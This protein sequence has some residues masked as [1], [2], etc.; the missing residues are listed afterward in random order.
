MAGCSR[1]EEPETREFFDLTELVL[2]AK[3]LVRDRWLPGHKTLIAC[4]NYYLA[5]VNIGT[6]SEH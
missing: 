1:S 3:F 5:S 4:V 6:S 2:L